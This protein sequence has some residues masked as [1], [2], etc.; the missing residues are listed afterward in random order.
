LIIG[1]EHS[2]ESNFADIS[3]RALK[4]LFCALNSFF[5][6]FIQADFYQEKLLNFKN[7]DKN[8]KKN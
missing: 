6:I 1:Q 3:Y 4:Q 5:L 8:C 2:T 7:L